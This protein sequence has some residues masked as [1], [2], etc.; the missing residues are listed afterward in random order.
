MSD[1]ETFP[2]LNPED[3][4]Q[5]A[6][7]LTRLRWRYPKETGTV[8]EARLLEVVREGLKLCVPLHIND[9]KEIL[10][11]LAL[12]LLLTPAQ[13]RSALLRAVL[14]RVVKAYSNWGAKKRL[15]FIYKYVV[16]RA[17]P[18]PEPDFGVWVM[19]DPRFS[20]EVTLEALGRVILADLQG[21]PTNASA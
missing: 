11:F 4:G 5:Q 3:P 15:D 21:P 12:S 13:K 20:P 8:T 7:Y 14:Y 6:L 1:G 18:D 19:N 2:P 10:R 9:P 17:P 16:G